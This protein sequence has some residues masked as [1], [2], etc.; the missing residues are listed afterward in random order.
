MEQGL[1][2]GGASKTVC[3]SAAGRTAESRSMRP[4]ATMPL[5]V[6]TSGRATPARGQLLRE[7]RERAKVELVLVRQVISGKVRHAACSC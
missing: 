2:I 6:T 7:Q 3:G 4:H 1:V 5:S